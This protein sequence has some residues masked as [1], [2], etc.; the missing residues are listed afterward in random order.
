MKI[1]NNSITLLSILC[2]LVL[3]FTLEIFWLR[4]EYNDELVSFNRET[5]ILL[6]NTVLELNDSLI[7]KKIISLG[8]DI[9]FNKNTDST[10]SGLAKKSIKVW[11]D[12]SHSIG[13]IPG[14]SEGAPMVKSMKLSFVLDSLNKEVIEKKYFTALSNAGLNLPT[15]FTYITAGV[16]SATDMI[17]SNNIIH[18]PGDSFKLEFDNLNWLLLKNIAP[19]IFFSIILSL[20]VV[21][22]FVLLYRSLRLQ[23]KLVLIKNDLISNI[24]H[25]L[26]T[27]ITTVG[28]ALEGLKK[29]KGQN[30][31]ITSSEYLAIAENELKRLT[32][33][34]DKVLNDA[35][36]EQNAHNY[37]FQSIHFSELL[38][39]AVESFRLIAEKNGAVITLKIETGEYEIDGDKDHLSNIIFNLLDNAV[40]YCESNAKINIHLT[41][42]NTHIKCSIKDNGI[43]IS[44]EFHAKI[45]EKFFRV[46]TGDLHTVKGYGLG[47]SYVMQVIKRHHGTIKVESEPNAGSTFI[48]SLPKTYAKK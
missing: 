7:Q 10:Q 8:N 32:I 4:T 36:G 9:E 26:K 6:R 27:P 47:L 24:S 35:L 13:K 43:G 46:P 15:Q 42:I 39:Q 31:P 37:N 38:K 5:S 40:K 33:L 2:S 11:I 29:F 34:T 22:S 41:D 25:E 19:Q 48:I 21:G 14:K 3:L 16:D 45:F 17:L 18:T 28:V 1:Q 44:K 20:L 23:Q 30:D 12:A